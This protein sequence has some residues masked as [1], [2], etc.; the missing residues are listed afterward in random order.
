MQNNNIDQSKKKV[1]ILYAIKSF[2]KIILPPIVI[3][4]T[5]LTIRINFFDYLYVSG[6]SM[7]PTLEDKQMILVDKTIKNFKRG[8]VVSFQASPNN[9]SPDSKDKMYIK[10]IIGLPGDTVTYKDGKLYVN[11]KEVNQKFLS[12]KGNDYKMESSE[13]TQKPSLSTIWDLGSLSEGNPNFNSWSQ[14]QIKVPD[15]SVFVLGDHRSVSFDSRYFGF[16]KMETIQGVNRSFFWDNEQQKYYTS[17]DFTKDF[18]VN[19]N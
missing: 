14:N 7:Y 8:Q 10:R 9:P 6:S 19:K 1:G 17:D 3:I 16:V 4:G 12:L 11:D 18:F 2:L 13:G 15:G 5:I